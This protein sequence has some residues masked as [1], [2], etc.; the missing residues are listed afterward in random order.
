VKRYWLTGNIVHLLCSPFTI[1]CLFPSPTTKELRLL[2]CKFNTQHSRRLPKQ[3][4]WTLPSFL[5]YPSRSRWVS[6][7]WLQFFSFLFSLITSLYLMPGNIFPL[8]CNRKFYLCSKLSQTISCFNIFLQ[9]YMSSIKIIVEQTA[10]MASG[11]KDNAKWN[12]YCSKHNKATQNTQD[13]QVAI[14]VNIQTFQWRRWFPFVAYTKDWRT[15]CETTRMI[16]N[17]INFIM[18]TVS[19]NNRHTLH[20]LHV[21]H[22]QSVAITVS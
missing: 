6:D 8:H 13:K 15:L 3:D 7:S 20:L 4:K 19:W 21:T 9:F 10:E 1:P 5:H 16:Q 22:F 17:V 18:I 12:I 14:T 2:A 11:D